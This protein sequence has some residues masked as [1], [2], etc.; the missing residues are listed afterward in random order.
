MSIFPRYDRAD[1]VEVSYRIE[2]CTIQVAPW[3]VGVDT[4]EGYMVGY[5]LD[6]YPTVLEPLKMLY[7]LVQHTI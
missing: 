4:Q 5:Q 6:G 3:L 7:E 2:G 1:E